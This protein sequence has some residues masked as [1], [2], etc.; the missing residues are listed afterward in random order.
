LRIIRDFWDYPVDKIRPRSDI[1]SAFDRIFSLI[2]ALCLFAWLIAVVPASISYAKRFGTFS[3][4]NIEKTA[5]TIAAIGGFTV[6][7]VLVAI[8][9]K[10]LFSD[11]LAGR[12]QRQNER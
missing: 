4:D 9:A 11:W 3:L 7:W 5:I 6:F 1:M 12:K 2:V 8:L 10:L